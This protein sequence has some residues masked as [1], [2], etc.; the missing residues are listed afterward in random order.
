MDSNQGRDRGISRRLKIRMTVVS[1]VAR[2]MIHLGQMVIRTA[3]AWLEW[4]E[5]P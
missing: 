5:R 4:S 1:W 2:E 3:Y